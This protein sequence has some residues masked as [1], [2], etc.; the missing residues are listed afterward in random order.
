MFL[1]R[2][3]RYRRQIPSA[4]LFLRDHQIF[5][6][7]IKFCLT[8]WS[9][10]YLRLESTSH[11]MKKVKNHWSKPMAFKLRPADVNNFSGVSKNLVVLIF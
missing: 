8:K 3:M 6:T 9:L 2:K 10:S 1:G 5:A 7:E 4:D 11:G